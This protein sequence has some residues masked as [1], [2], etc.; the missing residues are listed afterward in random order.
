MNAAGLVYVVDDD[1]DLATSLARLIERSGYRARAY[2][3][4]QSLL[5][6]CTEEAPHCI[7]SDVMM[8]EMDG[9]ML[10]E[11]LRDA[12][13]AAAVIFMTAWPKTSAAVDAIREFGGVDYLQKPLEEDRLI[14]SII[15]GIGWSES[16]RAA[17]ARLSSLTARERDVFQ[18]LTRGLSNKMIAATLDIK[19]KTVEDHRAAIMAKTRSNSVA[20]LIEL[21]RATRR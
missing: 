5:A 3:S 8:S 13:P 19:P 10:A 15:H 9:F 18:L 20:Q 14:E 12:A 11:R 1:E 21:E 2:F 6:A 7:V 16:R 17:D 4:P